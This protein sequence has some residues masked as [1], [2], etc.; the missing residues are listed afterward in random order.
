MDIRVVE[1]YLIWVYLKSSKLRS[2]KSYLTIEKFFLRAVLELLLIPA[3]V[4]SIGGYL[5]VIREH[6]I[7]VI[8]YI[9]IILL[10][11]SFV[12][13]L[14]IRERKRFLEKLTYESLRTQIIAG[15]VVESKEWGKIG[16]DLSVISIVIIHF[17]H[18]QNPSMASVIILAAMLLVSALFIDLASAWL[19]LRYLLKKHCSYLETPADARYQKTE[20]EHD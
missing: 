10:L 11:T 3:I 8:H 20:D 7:Q 2:L 18:R 15:D 19:Y 4:F 14:S 5:F 1:K 17:I 9:I 6:N 16:G 13:I 12:T